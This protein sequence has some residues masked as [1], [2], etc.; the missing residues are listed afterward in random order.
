[1]AYGVC[2]YFINNYHCSQIITIITHLTAELSIVDESGGSIDSDDIA[3][4]YSNLKK[5]MKS[6]DSSSIG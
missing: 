1:M 5:T 4:G 3:G 6:S 2:V